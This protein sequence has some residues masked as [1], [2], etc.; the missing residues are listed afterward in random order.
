M[1]SY[2]GQKDFRLSDSAPGR[3]SFAQTNSSV[4]PEELLQNGTIWHH[5]ERHGIPFRN[6]GEGFE[7]AGV[8]E[9]AGLMPTGARY[10]T[11]VPMP[12][13]LY[14]NHVAYLSAVQHEYSGSVPRRCVHSRDRRDVCQTG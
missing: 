3:L 7:L 1:A 12:D 14:R 9:G 5:L 11:N 6:F 2:G 8:D 4:H 10:L 13:P